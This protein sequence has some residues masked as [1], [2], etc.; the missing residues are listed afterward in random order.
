MVMMMMKRWMITINDIDFIILR[1]HTNLKKS[2][3][4]IILCLK[5]SLIEIIIIMTNQRYYRNTYK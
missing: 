1:Q 5:K 3:Q 4:E 2:T